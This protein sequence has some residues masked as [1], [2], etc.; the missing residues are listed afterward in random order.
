MEFSSITSD[1]EGNKDDDGTDIDVNDVLL[2][3]LFLNGGHEAHLEFYQHRGCLNAEK[4]LQNTIRGAIDALDTFKYTKQFAGLEFD[5]CYDRRRK[6]WVVCHELGLPCFRS[7]KPTLDD[8]LGAIVLPLLSSGRK[9]QLEVKSAVGDFV[10]LDDLILK[11][12]L[13][14]HITVTSFKLSAL[15]IVAMIQKDRPY[16]YP[17]AYFVTF[18]W[19]LSRRMEAMAAIT[20]TTLT[21]SRLFLRVHWFGKGW[22]AFEETEVAAQKAG[23]MPCLYSGINHGR[24]LHLL[25]ESRRAIGR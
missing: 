19:T 6:Q 25:M 9:L 14:N 2:P 15:Q 1:K 8:Y 22:S 5:T 23:L 20:R 11:Y 12:N 10:K 16:K 21:P 18:R 17:V 7:C 4:K 13:V 24:H 3:S